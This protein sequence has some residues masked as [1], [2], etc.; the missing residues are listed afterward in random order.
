MKMI[1]IIFMEIYR[2]QKTKKI[3]K[4]KWS[5]IDVFQ[6]HVEREFWRYSAN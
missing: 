2:K 4:L 6:T 5:T 3:H 1:I